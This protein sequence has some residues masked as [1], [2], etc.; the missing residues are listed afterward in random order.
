MTA[1]LQF[2]QPL[3]VEAANGTPPFSWHQ[4]EAIGPLSLAVPATPKTALLQRWFRT[5]AVMV[6]VGLSVSVAPSSFTGQRSKR[7]E[8]S[9][10]AAL[11]TLSFSLEFEWSDFMER[12]ASVA[13]PNMNLRRDRRNAIAHRGSQMQITGERYPGAIESELGRSGDRA[14]LIRRYPPRPRGERPVIREASR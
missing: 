4:T 10:N 1:A 11:R 5:G 14:R 3:A 13:H 2:D 7:N 9:E 12:F 6:T 8:S